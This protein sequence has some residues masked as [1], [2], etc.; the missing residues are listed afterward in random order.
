MASALVA[1][2]QRPVRRRR[3]ARRLAVT[4]AAGV[5]EERFLTVN[6]CQQWVTMRG[7]DRAN[8]VL[9]VLHGGPGASYVPFNSWITE[10]EKHFTI[11]Q[12]DQPGAGKT[13]QRNGRT[14]P[15]GLSLSRLAADGIETVSQLCNLFD[16]RKVILLGSSV[17]SLIGL[18]MVKRRPD[19]FHAYVGVN[20]NSPGSDPVVYRLA[21]RSAQERGDRKGVRLLADMGPDPSHWTVGQHESLMKLAIRVTPGVPNMVSDLMLPALMFAPCYTM[22]DIRDYQRAMTYSLGGLFEELRSFDR[23]DA[24][25]EFAVP[26]SFFAGERDTVTPIE[27]A[28]EYYQNIRAP[29]K[30]FV[31]IQGAGH[32]AEFADPRQFLEKLLAGVRP[33]ATPQ[34]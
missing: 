4:S 23:R 34:T 21:R 9:L 33:F 11:V 22:S 32:L 27:T 6:G 15:R 17:G 19:L 5:N 7:A 31:V 28:R 12:W 20:Q 30:E 2:L 26:I 3:N 16:C 10:W 24:R 14:D 8:P 1:V 18:R 29:H 13:F 25:D